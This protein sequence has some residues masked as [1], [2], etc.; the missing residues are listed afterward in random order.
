MDVNS[1]NYVLRGQ[2]VSKLTSDSIE[3]MALN[4]IAALK[5]T[6]NTLS[7]MDK[8]L[9]NLWHKYRINVE[10]HSDKGWIDVAYAWC[11]PEEFT[12]SIPEQLYNRIINGKDTQALHIIFHE[13]GHL[14]LGH[15]AVLHYSD[16][17]PIQEEDAEWQADTFAYTI[18]NFLGGGKYGQLNLF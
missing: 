7:N 2:R 10:I 8:F 16:T 14:L 3:L 11:E 5:I 15:K 12:I 9:D 13:L 4:T 1:S 17:A 18:L 6:H